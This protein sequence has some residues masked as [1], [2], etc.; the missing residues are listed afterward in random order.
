MALQ[1]MC[2]FTMWKFSD[3]HGVKVEAIR[4]LANGDLRIFNRVGKTFQMGQGN[5]LYVLNKPFGGLNCQVPHGPV[6]SETGSQ[7][8]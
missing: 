3:F 1:V 6:H 2:Y 7:K 4:V 5:Y 8:Y